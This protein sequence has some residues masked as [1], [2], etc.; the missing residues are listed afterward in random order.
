MIPEAFDSLLT[1]TLGTRLCWQ[2]AHRCPCTDEYGQSDRECPICLGRGRYWDTPS[3]EFRAGV[4]GLTGRALESMQLRFGPG[5]TGDGTISLPST[6]P[7]YADVG[8]GDRF[9]NLDAFDTLEWTLAKGTL[10]L[11]PVGAD[12]VGAY[13]RSSGQLHA[14]PPPVPSDDR[15]SVAVTTVITMLAPRRYEVVKAIPQT[16]NWVPGLPKKV[17]VQMLDLS[18]R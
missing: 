6:S 4:V 9:S 7:A 10:V 14:V 3:D 13:I 18:T 11:L 5:V 2:K 16:R 1:G 12:I 8:E 17:L 15:V